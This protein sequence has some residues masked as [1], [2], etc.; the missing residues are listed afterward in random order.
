MQLKPSG[1]LVFLT[2]DTALS[3]CSRCRR[4]PFGDILCLVLDSCLIFSLLILQKVKTAHKTLTS[5]SLTLRKLSTAGLL[6]FTLF[7]YYSDCRLF[8]FR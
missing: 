2:Q 8:R 1:Y 3:N 6:I 4:R 5:P 7:T